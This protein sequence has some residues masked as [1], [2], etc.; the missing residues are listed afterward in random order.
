MSDLK[1][2]K[3]IEVQDWM[4]SSETQSVMNVL[5]SKGQKA[6]FVGGCVRNAVLGEAVEDV[7]IAT[8]WTPEQVM[9][10]LEEAGIK[11]VPTGI[12]HGTVTAVIEKKTFEIT[13]LRKDVETD[14]R[15]AVVAFTQDWLQ[16]AQRRDF[17]MN[18]LLADEK[19]RI[20][21]PTGDGLVD[22]EAKR[23]VFV[24]DPAQR[25]T[26]DILRILRF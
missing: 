3:T 4:A 24:G 21:D 10:K 5:N 22:L 23:V 16:D 18:T 12:E 26:E 25:I 13:T 17:T 8:I 20:Y 2:V 1:P 6:L 19:G 9:E 14:G 15:R 7:D 11:A